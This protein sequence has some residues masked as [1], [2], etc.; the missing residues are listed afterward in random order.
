MKQTL[1][2]NILNKAAGE[3]AMPRDIKMSN[4][5][6]QVVA[7]V[8]T[9]LGFIA[10]DFLTEAR[11]IANTS[12][13]VIVAAADI[14]PVVTRSVDMEGLS[15]E[16]NAS[17]AAAPAAMPQAP[18]AAMTERTAAVKFEDADIAFAGMDDVREIGAIRSIAPQDA[19]YLR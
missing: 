15:L 1:L 7:V 2:N 13:N 10:H 8:A 11:P 16:T 12:A 6:N 4:I 18:A 14:D 17:H 19:D 5:G 3:M 9:L